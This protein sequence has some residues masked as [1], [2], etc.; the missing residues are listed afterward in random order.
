MFEL[1]FLRKCL[2]MI[3]SYGLSEEHR[4]DTLTS[5]TPSGFSL[6]TPS[7]SPPERCRQARES[8]RVAEAPQQTLITSG[9]KRRSRLSLCLRTDLQ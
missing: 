2:N 3:V 6:S 1:V 7:P 4:T 9:A 8:P 5:K